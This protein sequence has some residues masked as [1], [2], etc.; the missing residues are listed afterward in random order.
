MPQ[1]NSRVSFTLMQ[2]YIGNFEIYPV[3]D[4]NSSQET[5]EIQQKKFQKFFANTF[6]DRL[7][8]SDKEIENLIQFENSEDFPRESDEAKN[9]IQKAKKLIYTKK[10]LLYDKS[11]TERNIRQQQ[12]HVSKHRKQSQTS[13]FYQET[14]GS[15]LYLH[16]INLDYI[17]REYECSLPPLEI[18]VELQDLYRFTQNDDL[19]YEMAALS[20]IPNNKDFWV[21]TVKM[22]GF[23][24]QFNMDCYLQDIAT[25]KKEMKENIEDFVKNKNDFNLYPDLQSVSTQISKSD[26]ML[27]NVNNFD[28]NLI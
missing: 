7:K 4:P 24:N 18:N 15:Q 5:K 23:L 1:E 17:L 6:E 16:P 12:N 13:F 2:S 3:L 26:P 22:K 25:Y 27:Q 21:S 11:G 8:I 19:K 9:S 14:N 28:K 20:H 10:D